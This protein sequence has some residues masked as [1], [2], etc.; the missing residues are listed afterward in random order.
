MNIDI[1]NIKPST[2]SFSEA[3]YCRMLLDGYHAGDARILALISAVEK[4]TTPVSFHWRGR[5]DMRLVTR[6][7]AFVR[8]AIT[9]RMVV[10]APEPEVIAEPEPEVVAKPK[11]KGRKPKS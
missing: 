9:E 3:Q 7:N 2:G 8:W 11:R 10:A 1:S 6:F 4:S 5:S